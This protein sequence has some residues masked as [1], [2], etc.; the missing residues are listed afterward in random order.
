MYDALDIAEYVLNF[1]EINKK[2]PITNLQL[3]KILY[4]IQGKYLQVNGKPIFDN[5]IE[6]WRYG[7]VIPDVYYWYSKYMDNP[8]T[9]I[10]YEKRVNKEDCKIINSVIDEKINID[11]WKLVKNTHE[12]DPWNDN[13]TLGQKN[14]IPLMD[15][16]SYF[17]KMKG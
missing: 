6:A 12:E 2:R 1:C 8:I 11:V 4:Y 13:Y 15:M 14:K 7:P 16:K 17:K 5:D 3:Q 9:K 10:K